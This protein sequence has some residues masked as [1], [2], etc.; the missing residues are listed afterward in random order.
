MRLEE[1]EPQE[2]QNFMSVPSPAEGVKR[3]LVRHIFLLLRQKGL[4]CK[5]VEVL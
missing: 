5:T 4:F 1:Y 3:R 2:I